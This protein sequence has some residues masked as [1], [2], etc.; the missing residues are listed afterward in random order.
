MGEKLYPLIIGKSKN[1][2][3]FRGIEM[4]KFKAKYLNSAKAWMTNP[5]FNIYLKGMDDFFKHEGRKI[6]LFLDNAP[7]HIVDEA[8][9]LTNVELS[10]FPP[11]MTSVLQPLD[12]G[13][14]R[15]LKALSRK[16]EVLTPLDLMEDSSVHASELAKKL[17]VLDAIKFIEKSW[18][19][20][21][22]ET[23]QTCFVKCGFHSYR[24]CTAARHDRNLATRTRSSFVGAKNWS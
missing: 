9:K 11:N 17:T 12:A 3:A 7:V 4:S 5:L 20:V 22:P 15:S 21:K 14:I 10:Y 19:L 1:P 24:S 13:I 16:F 8:T 18:D 23:I 6:L 2:R